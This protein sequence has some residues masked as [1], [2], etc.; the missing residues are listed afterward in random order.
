MISFRRSRRYGMARVREASTWDAFSNR[1]VAHGLPLGEKE[2]EEA[3]LL[4]KCILRSKGLATDVHCTDRR[5][6]VALPDMPSDFGTGGVMELLSVVMAIGHRFE[7]AYNVGGDFEF[8]I[9]F[10]AK[11]CMSTTVGKA[12]EFS[13]RLKTGAV[14]PGEFWGAFDFQAPRA[15]RIHPGKDPLAFGCGNTLP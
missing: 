11:G 2:R 14:T 9:D 3:A 6:S 7:D 13:R 4:V 15:F 10:R 12:T 8:R 5:L 1:R